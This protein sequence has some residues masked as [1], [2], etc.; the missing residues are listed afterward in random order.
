MRFGRR[1]LLG[2]SIMALQGCADSPTDP[3]GSSLTSARRVATNAYVP[4]TRT[5]TVANGASVTGYVGDTIVF[6]NRQTE[7][8][9]LSWAS[10]ST[11]LRVDSFSPTVLVP[12]KGRANTFTMRASGA[13]TVRLSSGGS[14]IA[15]PVT[16]A[17]APTTALLVPDSALLKSL[18][19][20]I[21]PP[22]D[23][24]PPPAFVAPALPRDSIDPR[25][26]A[27]NG[28]IFNVPAGDASALQAAFQNAR[29]G[30]QIVLPD[31]AV[32]RG[33]FVIPA[34]A[35]GGSG[36]VVVR[37]S[38]LPSAG[39]VS[40]STAAGFAKI[41]TGNA[42]PALRTQP[43]ARGWHFAGIEIAMAENTPERTYS[44]VSVG[45]G[46]ETTLG[47]LP[48]DFVFDRVYVH[49]SSTGNSRRCIALNGGAAA[50]VHSWVSECHDNGFDSQA[51]ASWGG[52]G[53]FRIE[54]NYLEASGENVLFGGGNSSVSGVVP[55][56]AIVRGNYLYKPLA[57]GGRWL[58][59]NL[60]EIKSGRR[61]LMEDNVLENSWIHGQTGFAVLFTASV[62]APHAVVSDLTFRRNVIKNTTGGIYIISR[63]P[64]IT[65]PTRRVLI[66]N[67]VFDHVGVDPL[68]PAMRGR[69]LQIIGDNEDLT[70]IQNTFAPSRMANVM[71]IGG[72]PGKRLVLVSN[73]FGPS[74][75]G[76]FGE[77]GREGNAAISAF[78]PNSTIRDNVLFERPAQLYPDGFIVQPSFSSDFFVDPL[79]GNWT[80]RSGAIGGGS[81][82]VTSIL[83]RRSVTQR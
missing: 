11:T 65:E 60:L 66:Q 55:S 23:V 26:P 19:E 46:E 57:W 5:V 21:E 54:N 10:R 71:M 14:R 42:Q 33:N 35:S 68:N 20:V 80:L 34:A 25:M 76:I 9:W 62:E 63:Y 74:E 4:V 7:S 75:Y 45:T 52:T 40:P 47:Q 67:N 82:G 72:A 27:S 28:R 44:I 24:A 83:D 79:R 41:I 39:R 8:R 6:T 16:V 43:G 48:T 56:D 30:D 61:I 73:M 22:I 38:T 1:A 13:S 58:V 2:A 15:V 50:V 3:T 12:V 69:G 81:A 59:K 49:G 18:P 31:R 36:R 64:G 77:N 51:V 29:A 32:F 78:Y 17:N 37:S 53:P 70:I